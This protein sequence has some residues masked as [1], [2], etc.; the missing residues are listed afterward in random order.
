MVV[1][2]LETVPRSL[3]GELSRWLL[4]VGPGIFVGQTSAL[5]RDLLWEKALDGKAV[6]GCYQAFTTNSEQ[7][8]DLRCS[9]DLERSV[10]HYHGLAL[11]AVKNAAW[12]KWQA[13]Q[14]ALSEDDRDC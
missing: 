9:E 12:K 14:R 13:K 7:G 2:I 8:Y 11:I 3:R 6:G 4:E 10:L 1:M 5:V